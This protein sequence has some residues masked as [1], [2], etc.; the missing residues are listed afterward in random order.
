MTARL[1]SLVAQARLGALASVA[2]IVG[3]LPV[4]CTS[5]QQPDGKA[6]APEG[7]SSQTPPEAAMVGVN[8]ACGEFGR[9]PGVY[10]RDYTLLHDPAGNLV[11]EAHQYFDR[12]SSGTYKQ[13]YDESG[14]FPTIGV[15]RLKPFAEWL[16]EHNA[17]GFIGEFGVPDDDRYTGVFEVGTE[18]Q[19]LL[20]PFDKLKQK[21]RTFAAGRGLRKIEF[22]PNPEPRGGRIYLGK[23]R[24]VRSGGAE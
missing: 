24:L 3:L 16:K 6:I 14:A 22:Q 7:S 11:Y 12:D 4:G 8:L 19:E 20:I 17:R 2:L 13:S 10:G 1:G 18:W 5:V 9:V 21:G 15:D 23:F